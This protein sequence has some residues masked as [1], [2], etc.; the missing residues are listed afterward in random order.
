MIRLRV[1]IAEADPAKVEE[2]RAALDGW[3]HSLVGTVRHG[4]DVV[5]SVEGLLPDLVLLSVTMPGLDGVEAIRQ[6][7]ARRPVPI[8]AVAPYS[9]L[10]IIERATIAGVMGY[11][12]RPVERK[13][14]GPAIALAI[15][16]FEELMALRKE[17]LRLKDSVTLHQQMQRAKGVMAHRM[18]LSE[19]EAQKKLQRFAQSERCSLLEASKRVTAADK[20]FCQLE[21]LA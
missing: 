5:A 9:D 2:L 18:R 16:R 13:A 15:S 10:D 7:M 19:M 20:F 4:R 14:L 3:G 6:I 11:L 12:V 17:M 1:L 8:I 21:A